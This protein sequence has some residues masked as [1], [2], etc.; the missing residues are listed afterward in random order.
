M[1]QRELNKEDPLMNKYFKT[2]KLCSTFSNKYKKTF[3]LCLQF[4]F[5]F[6]GH[7][8]FWFFYLCIPFLLSIFLF[9]FSA[10]N[11]QIGEHK[12]LI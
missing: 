4:K 11:I 5:H 7:A 6:D 1:G 2:D 8:V 12:K 9:S 3:A 10:F